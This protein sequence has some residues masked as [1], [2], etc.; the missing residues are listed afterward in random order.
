ML[1]SHTTE[2]REVSSANSFTVKTN[3]IERSLMQV[4]KKR[5]PKMEPCGT[6]G[7]TG[8]YLDV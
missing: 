7:L 2:D 4:R 1:L 8:N 5:G 3:A 6:P